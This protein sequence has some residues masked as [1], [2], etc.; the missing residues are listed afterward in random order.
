MMDTE[1]SLNIKQEIFLMEEWE[2]EESI[3]GR[4]SILGYDMD[5]TSWIYTWAVPKW[6]EPTRAES[7]KYSLESSDYHSYLVSVRQEHSL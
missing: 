5:S 6:V 7:I 2:D 1:M 4:L 3:E